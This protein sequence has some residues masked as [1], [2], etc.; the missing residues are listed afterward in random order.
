MSESTEQMPVAVLAGGGPDDK[1]AKATGAP[2]KA[3]AEVGG[4]PLV[5]WVLDALN[6]AELVSEIV[7]VQGP[8]QPL[9]EQLVAPARLATARGPEVLDTFRAA[10]A[11][12]P[13][14]ERILCVTADLPL[15]TSEA[16][17]DFVG[18]CLP[19]QAEVSYAIV[20]AD[21]VER[22]AP[23][24][25]KTVARLREGR[26]TGGG[27]ACVSR[28]FILEHGPSIA[29]VFAR[30]KSKLGMLSMFGW[31][32]VLRLALGRLSVTELEKRASEMLGCTL[33]AVRSEYAGLALDVDDAD[34]LE[35]AGRHVGQLTHDK[36][37]SQE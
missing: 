3:L 14:S 17:D 15:L 28:R 16:I 6:G 18:S 13:E 5:A 31:A 7:V 30:R 33:Q 34:D 24:R 9:S 2:C 21:A 1:V 23:G 29:E 37:S 20:A 36:R 11:A 32:F 12:L 27:A 25:G 35:L 22:A 26:V 10:V 8:A 4:R 19:L